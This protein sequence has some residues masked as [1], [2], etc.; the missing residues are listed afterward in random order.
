MKKN[1]INFAHP[2]KLS[3]SLASQ[4]SRNLLQPKSR[5]DGKP[6]IKICKKRFW[7]RHHN[8]YRKL[9]KTFKKK[10]RSTKNQ[11]LGPGVG[12]VCGRY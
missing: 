6:K 8:Y 10:A 3:D 12:Y 4:W 11:N 9:W 7:S 1:N 2:N 5:W